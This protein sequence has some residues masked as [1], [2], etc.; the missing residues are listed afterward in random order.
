MSQFIDYSYI[1]WIHSC[2]WNFGK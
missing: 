2:I 1:H